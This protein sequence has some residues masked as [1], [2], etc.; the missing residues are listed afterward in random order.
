MSFLCTYAVHLSM[1]R[2]Y[3]KVSFLSALTLFYEIELRGCTGSFSYLERL[4]AK[5]RRPKG[6]NVVTF[7]IK[8]RGLRNDGRFHIRTG[9]CEALT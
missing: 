2:L 3:E 6:A 1:K 9:R 7:C 4:L 8:P 5:W